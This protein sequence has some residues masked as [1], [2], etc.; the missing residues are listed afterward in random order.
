MEIDY[1]TQTLTGDGVQ[2]VKLRPTSS[3]VSDIRRSSWRKYMQGV[4]D[5]TG[6]ADRPSHTG[7]DIRKAHT[8]LRSNGRYYVERHALRVFIERHTHPS[9][10][11]THPSERHTHPSSSA[12]QAPP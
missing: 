10:R 9:E 4:E 12:T 2:N 3:K 8:D 11:H 1:E 6:K 5:I 7:P